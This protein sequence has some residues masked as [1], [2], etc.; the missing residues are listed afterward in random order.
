MDGWIKNGLYTYNVALFRTKKE[1]NPTI[2]DRV[3]ECWGHCTTW[4]NPIHRRTNTTCFHWYQVSKI[5]KEA[6]NSH[7]SQEETSGLP[8]AGVMGK[9]VVCNQQV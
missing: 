5:V 8:G 1:G 7:R 6:N 9:W 4:N 2:C 3:Y